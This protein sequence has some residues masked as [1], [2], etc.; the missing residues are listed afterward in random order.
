M[1]KT[2]GR[3]LIVS[4]LL[5]LGITLRP[6]GA[7]A[8]DAAADFS[9]AANPNSGVWSYGSS[10]GV[11]STFLLS[12]IST[13]NYQGLSV[14]GW[15]VDQSPAGVPNVL[16]NGTTHSATLAVTTYQPGQ[17]A[18]SPGYSNE[19]SVIRWTAPFS[20]TCTVAATFTC[21]SAAA[22]SV[23]GSVD[24]H[25][26]HNGVSIFDNDAVN[27]T[28]PASFSGSEELLVGD[29]I[30]FAV[31]NGGNGPNEDT[32]GLSATITPTMVGK[33]DLT[34]SSLT[35]PASTITDSNVL[36]SILVTNR[37]PDNAFET[38]ITNILP[39]QVDY[40]ACSTSTNGI[41]SA[42]GIGQIVGTYPSLAAARPPLWSLPAR[43]YARRSTARC[44]PIQQ[45]SHRLLSTLF[46]PIIKQA[47]C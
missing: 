16:H 40:V 6:D 1:T 15:L 9:S 7:R 30:D 20:G 34:I 8:F 39:S 12:S 44:L 38:T 29:T 32:T 24:V 25:I 13:Q 22:L 42:I 27:E 19:M 37:G 14:S 45:R 41:C 17:L 5:G 33:A 10:Y 4:T 36:F 11:G 28:A 31:G 23:G 35:T 43:C 18:E 2:T 47:W 46:R 3:N 21:L 26:L